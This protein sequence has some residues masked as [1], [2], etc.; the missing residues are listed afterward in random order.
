MRY[1]T[2]HNCTE[3]TKSDFA[4]DAAWLKAHKNRSQMIRKASF[5]EFETFET[6]QHCAKLGI[7]Q[8]PQ[9]WVMVTRSGSSNHIIIPIWL[10]DQCFPTDNSLQCYDTCDSDDALQVILHYINH[11]KGFDTLEFLEWVQRVQST[12]NA[13][14]AKQNGAVN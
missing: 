5:A 12:M 8:P 10:G 9:L 1:A 14:A 3:G 4:A 7:P 6:R 11:N 2:P 13:A